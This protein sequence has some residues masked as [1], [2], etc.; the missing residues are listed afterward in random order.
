MATFRPFSGLRYD[1]AVVGD[2]AAVTA[3]PYDVI[4]AAQRDALYA[5][6]PYNVVRIDLS[7]EPDPY[8]SAAATLAGWREEVADDRTWRAGTIH[9]LVF[10]R[11]RIDDI[12][13]DRLRPC[14]RPVEVDRSGRRRCPAGR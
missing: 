6:S 9:V 10:F 8:G 7:R 5:K 13:R 1:P 14:G 3:P 11:I 4:D 12:G 2:P